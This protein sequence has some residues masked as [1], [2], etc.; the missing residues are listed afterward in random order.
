MKHTVPAGQVLARRSTSLAP[1][2]LIL[3]GGFAG[4]R[5]AIALLKVCG[6]LL[7]V[8]ITLLSER[9]FFLFPPMLAEAAT[10]AV[11]TRHVLHPIRPL[12]GAWGGGVRRDVGRGD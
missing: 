1:R 10:G 8:H 12:C 9:N 11:E 3:G 4:V 5:T 7:P 2:I 6:G